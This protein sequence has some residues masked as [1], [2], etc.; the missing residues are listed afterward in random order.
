[1][2]QLIY[3]LKS[4]TID[5]FQALP[6]PGFHLNARYIL[7]GSHVRHFGDGNRCVLLRS[8]NFGH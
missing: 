8:K 5:G 3:T 2:L 6:S 4:T 1:M 7:I